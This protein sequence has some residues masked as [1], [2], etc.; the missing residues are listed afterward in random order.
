M[1]AETPVARADAGPAPSPEA[2]GVVLQRPVIAELSGLGVLA[3]QGPDAESFLNG[4]LTI[5]MRRIGPARWQLGAYCTPKG[6]VIAVV[7][8]WRADDGFYLSM[9][10]DR[11]A[12]MLARLSRYTLRAK[13]R[14]RDD[15]AAW[16]LFGITGP[17]S[18]AL[19]LGG[20]W[21][22]PQADWT[23]TSPLAGARL[24]RLPASPSTGS[25]WMLAVPAGAAGEARKAIEG[26]LEV[27][28]AL[29]Q[30]S[31]I[32]AGLPDVFALTE[33]RFVPQ[34][35]N[36]DVLGGVHFGKGCYPGQEVVARS[37]YL[38]KLRR[39]MFRGHADQGQA[40]DDVTRGDGDP[41]VVGTVVLAAGSPDGGV[42]LLLEFSDDADHAGVLRVATAG[43]A[44]ITVTPPP[45]PMIN[46]TA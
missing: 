38:G 18:E 12:A 31:K 21:E 3:V 45:Y 15:S 23:S 25:R 7:E 19:L 2:I 27:D 10:S 9:P 33:E 14:I 16:K 20:G 24:A 11:T 6:R 26:L 13:V 36:L 8:V 4:Q 1:L 46:P 29:W 34:S 17:G 37:Q 40:G 44:S 43:S 22:L 5:D 35:L 32:D 30:W 42:D 39:R 28:P 41:Q